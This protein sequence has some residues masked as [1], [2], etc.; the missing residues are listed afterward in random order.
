VQTVS[1]TVVTAGSVIQCFGA[2]TGSATANALGGTLPY[3]YTWSVTAPTQTTQ[4]AT[5]LC[6]GTYTVLV[7]DQ[8]GCSNTGTITFTNPPDIIIAPTQTNI[9]CFNNCN[10]AINSN[11]SGGTGLLTYSWSPGSITTANLSSL[12]AGTYTL[13]V[14]DSKGCFKIQTFTIATSPSITATF[15]VTNPSACVVNNGSV[16]AT[17]SGGTGSG[18]T[19]TWSP[20]GGVGINT[21]CYSSLNAGPYSLIVADGSGCTTTLSA[22]L[23]N[24]TGPTLNINTQSVTCFGSST[25]AAT[26]T[27]VGVGPFTFTWTPVVGFTTIGNTSTASGLNTGTYNISVKN[28]V[29][30]CITSQSIVIAQPTN[31]LTI[32]STITPV[33]CFSAFNG[34]ITILP[35]GDILQ[36][37]KIYQAWALELIH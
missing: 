17:P 21:S 11:V 13:K 24:P 23:T 32:T 15:T 3:T 2:C 18:Y 25:G 27:A 12:C 26:V 37:H 22:I 8:L 19:F 16:C 7:K 36:L 29:T 10:G 31:S 33:K 35:S 4:L 9:T 20:S 30:G 28:T 14:T 34:S 6:A 1:V 5:N